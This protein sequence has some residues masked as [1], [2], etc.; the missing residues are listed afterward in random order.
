MHDTDASSVERNITHLLDIGR[1]SCWD[2][3]DAAAFYRLFWDCLREVA[4]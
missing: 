1:R 4:K 3:L 2:C